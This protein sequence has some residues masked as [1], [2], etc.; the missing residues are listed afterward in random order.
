MDTNNLETL[1]TFTGLADPNFAVCD[2]T[3][4]IYTTQRGMARILEIN[5]KTL[6]RSLQGLAHKSDNSELYSLFSTEECDIQPTTGRLKRFGSIA[7]HTLANFYSEEQLYLITSVLRRDLAKKMRSAGT[8]LYLRGI[9]GLIE[10][11]NQSQ[12][13]TLPTKIE[14]AEAYMK[15]AKLELST[16]DLPGLADLDNRRI[17]YVTKHQGLPGRITITE[18]LSANPLP[19]YLFHTFCKRVNYQARFQTN[20][21][22]LTKVKGINRHGKTKWELAFPTSFVP[23]MDSIHASL[24]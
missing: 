12:T 8:H 10:P 13:Q 5:R 20:Y 7:A 22:E 18:Y 23:T 24:T 17:D 4:G 11:T 9:T 6:Q 14:L 16:N 21:R 3:G 2:V 19:G 15:V 1:R